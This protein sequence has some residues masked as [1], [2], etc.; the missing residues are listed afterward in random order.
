[1][2]LNYVF[3]I[4]LFV[5]AAFFSLTAKLPVLETGQFILALFLFLLFSMLYNHLNMTTKTG[6]TDI[7]YGISYGLAIAL[8]TGPLGLFIYQIVYRTSVYL[9]R[10]VRKEHRNNAGINT[11]YNIGSFTLANV[12]GYYIFYALI[13]YFAQIPFG[14]W[15]LIVLLIVVTMYFSD[16]LLLAM[17]Y[18][19][20]SIQTREEAW[21]FIK[22]RSLLDLLKTSFTNG[23][24]FIFLIEGRWELLIA[25]FL[26]N[27]LVSRSVALRSQNLQHKMERDKFEDMAYTDYLTGVRNRAFMA[28]TMH[29]ASMLSV[30]VGVVVA[31]IDK[32]KQVNDMYNHAVGDE[33]IRHFAL[34]LQNN[35]DKDDFLFRTG[36]EEFTMLLRGRS[37]SETEEFL[38]KTRRIVEESV[39]EA[40]FNDEIVRIS[41]T[42]SFGLS[43]DK[44]LDNSA[45]EKGYIHADNLLF[46]SK[47]SG[48]NI[49]ISKDYRI[50]VEA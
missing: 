48:R 36:G 13:S 30:P 14:F 3:N 7:D 37:F 47:R 11:V 5:I 6:A 22:D 27:Y 44:F 2:K 35:L 16:A 50:P 43:Y 41:Y 38:Q 40:A 49:V 29:S 32:F 28:K 20:K 8:F 12:A 34:L 18:L 10:K 46:E 4:T 31:D 24:L 42:A 19:D 21:V 23:L 25:L 33:V 15:L 45:M 39:V 17:L 9:I 1:M 26:L